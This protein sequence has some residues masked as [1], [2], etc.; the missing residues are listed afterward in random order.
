M[1]LNASILAMNR[2][3]ATSSTEMLRL[4]SFTHHTS[5]IDQSLVKDKIGLCN[6][7][8]IRI[9]AES[10]NGARYSFLHLDR[11]SGPC[12][13]CRRIFPILVDLL[14]MES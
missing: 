10:S 6:V 14:R 9:F 3:S 12:I 2:K 8:S 7:K 1:D 13:R 5:L 4:V 11:K